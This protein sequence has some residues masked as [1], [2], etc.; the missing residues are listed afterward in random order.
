M[1]ARLA[2]L[3]T[4]VNLAACAGPTLRPS[5]SP[6]PPNREALL[7]LPGFGYGPS[8]GEP[9]QALAASMAR[10]GV[11]LYVPTYVTRSG[12][13]TSREKLERFI[14][15]NRLDRYERILFKR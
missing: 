5:L 9:F 7:V 6:A 10:D 8:E 1:K 11:D 12:L 14:R 15:D 3:I 4:C 13:A 2:V